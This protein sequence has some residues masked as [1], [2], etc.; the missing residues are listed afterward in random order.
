MAAITPEITQPIPVY[1]PDPGFD[2]EKWAV[3]YENE[4]KATPRQTSAKVTTTTSLAQ[5]ME[6]EANGLLK[7]MRQLGQLGW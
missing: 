1:A 7:M 5:S 6:N 4:K 3:T 2:A